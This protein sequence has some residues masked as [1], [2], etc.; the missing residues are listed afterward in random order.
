M[1]FKSERFKTTQ[2]KTS[3]IFLDA[4]IGDDINSQKIIS[5][6]KGLKDTTIITTDLLGAG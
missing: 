5:I 2:F 3:P 4:N 6:E 1:A